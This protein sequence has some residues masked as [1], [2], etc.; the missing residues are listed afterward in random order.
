MKKT[1]ILIGLFISSFLT[2]GAWTANP[3]TIFRYNMGMTLPHGYEEIELRGDLAYNV[4][5]N[6]IEA[7][8]SDEAV[9]IQFNQSFGSVS[10][11]LYDSANNCV[12]GS[13]V[14]TTVQSIVIFPINN[15][16]D[17][18]YILEINNASGSS[19]GGFDH[20]NN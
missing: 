12:Y 10:I 3:E 16:S 6:A 1:L 18:V 13:T 17:G 5:P 7:G 4:G 20:T 2:L 8:V 9:Y 19:E 15:L 14:N 11:S